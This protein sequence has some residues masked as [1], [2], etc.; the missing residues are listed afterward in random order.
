MTSSTS[1]SLDT[2]LLWPGVDWKASYHHPAAS[3]MWHSMFNDGR[4][5]CGLDGVSRAGRL[6]GIIPNSIGDVGVGCRLQH[7]MVNAAG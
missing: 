5:S 1:D 7:G 3:G 6:S 2:E 4:E